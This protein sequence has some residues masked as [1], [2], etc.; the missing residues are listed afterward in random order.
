MT[1]SIQWPGKSGAQYQYWIHPLGT[2]FKSTPGNYIYAKLTSAGWVPLYVG[3]TGDLS[4]RLANHEKDS[5]ARRN[6]A[7]HI[8]AH[9]S[10]SEAQRLAEEKD[11]IVRWQPVCNDQLVA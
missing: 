3:Q 7:T 10:T 1:D 9:T 8:H 5:E 11:L 4:A 2:T 6:G